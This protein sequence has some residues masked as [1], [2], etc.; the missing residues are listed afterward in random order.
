ME[1]IRETMRIL[2]VTAAIAALAMS[3]CASTEVSPKELN[4]ANEAMKSV[5][6]ATMECS[7]LEEKR[8]DLAVKTAKAT[9]KPKAVDLASA[10]GAAKAKDLKPGQT[11]ASVA[12]TTA[13]SIIPGG[14][15]L[16]LITG[17]ASRTAKRNAALGDASA[18]LAKLEGAM[19]VKG[20]QTAA[21]A[22]AAEPQPAEE[23]APAEP[24]GQ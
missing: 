10:E 7:E 20:C 13:K 18:T 22:E 2:L 12:M 19:L 24:S 16:P 11:A 21:P 1:G 23:A 3:G 14:G 8:N 5:D 17:S 4:A 15:F 9:L 6:V